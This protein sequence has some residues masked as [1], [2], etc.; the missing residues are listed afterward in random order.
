MGVMRLFLISE[1]LKRYGKRISERNWK[2]G[3]DGEV[4]I[5]CQ[6]IGGAVNIG[7]VVKKYQKN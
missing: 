2:E 4:V 3:G 6:F 5:H 7:S 1:M